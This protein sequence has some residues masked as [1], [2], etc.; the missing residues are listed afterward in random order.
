MN[1]DIKL[2][3][4]PKYHKPDPIVRLIGDT[5][6]TNI[7]ADGVSCKG[8]VDSGAQISTMTRSFTKTFGLLDIERTE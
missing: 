2:K 5:N 3:K 7:I 4:S 8:L 6:D 1:K